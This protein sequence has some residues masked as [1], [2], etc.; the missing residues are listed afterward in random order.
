M[1]SALTKRSM[2]SVS[3]SDLYYS[4]TSSAARTQLHYVTNTSQ[5]DTKRRRGEKEGETTKKKAKREEQMVSNN[6]RAAGETGEQEPQSCVL[7][8]KDSNNKE[9]EEWRLVPDHTHRAAL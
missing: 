1:G 5:E 2:S 6:V 4:V 8:N 9:K 3:H 7:S